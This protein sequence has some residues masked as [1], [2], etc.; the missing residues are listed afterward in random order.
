MRC[1]RYTVDVGPYKST[2][3]F[4]EDKPDVFTGCRKRT[5]NERMNGWLVR[6]AAVEVI[7]LF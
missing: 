1:Y 6:M 4:C 2:H 7:R 3:R 5:L